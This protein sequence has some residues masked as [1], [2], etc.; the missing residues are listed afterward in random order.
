VVDGTEYFTHTYEPRV[1]SDGWVHGLNTG[2]VGMGSDNS[3][4]TFDNIVVQILRPETTFEGI[5]AFPDT[6][7]TI[8]FESVSGDWQLTPDEQRYNGLTGM[9]E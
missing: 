5:E 9:G 4:G 1:D 7:Q 6:D 8:T 3:R 2:M